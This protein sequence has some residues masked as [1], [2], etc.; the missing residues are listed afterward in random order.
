[1]A[2]AECTPQL[3][4]AGAKQAQVKAAAAE[5]GRPW[6]A[7]ESQM[8]FTYMFW[9]LVRSIDSNMMG[10]RPARREPWD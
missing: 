8:C 1:M 5:N 10:R 4:E 6:E 2:R 9:G 7:P 3:A